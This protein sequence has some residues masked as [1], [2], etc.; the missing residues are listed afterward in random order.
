MSAVRRALGAGVL[1]VVLVATL[2]AP[3]PAQSTPPLTR[4]QALGQLRASET[5]ERRRG[6]A[7]LS[8][9]GRMPDVPALV[10][11][12]RDPDLVVRRLA[13]Q[14]I[15]QVWSRSGDEDVDA[16]FRAGVAQMSRGD[17]DEATATFTRIIERKPDF[18]EGWNKRATVHYLAG[19]YDKSLRDCDEVMK[20]NPLHFGA[21]SGYG[22]IHLQLG[23]PDK[24]LPYF[25]R[26]LAIN[27]T[28]GQVEA[29][30]EQLKRLLRQR[31]P[32]AAH[33]RYDL[34]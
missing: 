21:L 18:A 5:E 23:E 28:L 16:L 25:E 14:S 31:K 12:L 3:L 13:Q 29:V 17:L 1:G 24:A 2:P 15:W 22:Q 30:I 4:E 9:L 10:Q 33:E 32:E 34:G 26:A 19:E 6:A 7:W 11:A 20:R 8:E 27:P